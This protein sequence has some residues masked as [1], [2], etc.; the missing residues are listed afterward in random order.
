MVFIRNECLD[1]SVDVLL[2]SI[3][4]LPRFTRQG[5]TSNESIIFLISLFNAVSW[6]RRIVTGTSGW[7]SYILSYIMARPSY[8]SARWCLHCTKPTHSLHSGTL[9]WL[10]VH[11]SLLLFLNVTRRSSKYQFNSFFKN[12]PTGG[13]N[14]Q[15][16]SLGENMLASTPPMRLPTN[17]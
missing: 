3:F 11:T 16:A 12:D 4:Q 9:S 15:S 2:Y 7:V 17:W 13:L 8:I 1:I 10:R 6:R 5:S 14:L